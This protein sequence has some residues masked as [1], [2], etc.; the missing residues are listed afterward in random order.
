MADV[1]V[2]PDDTAARLRDYVRENPSVRKD[3]YDYDDVDP[4]QG[5]CYLL[6]EAYFHAT[7][8][9]ETYDVYRLDWGAV[10][11]AYEGAHWFLRRSDD[12]VIVDLSLST[13]DDGVDVPWD[14]A[15]HR[16]FIT[17]YTPSNRAARLLT[18]L[19]L[20]Y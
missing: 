1:L 10:D 7:G 3:E 4:V 14:Q 2:E 8:G 20:D 17:G 5:A 6:A 13:P 18:A 16:A 15:R 19:N 12:G 11:P 9:R